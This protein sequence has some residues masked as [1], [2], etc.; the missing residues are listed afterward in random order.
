MHDQLRTPEANPLEFSLDAA[1]EGMAAWRV[2]PIRAWLEQQLTPAHPD[3]VRDL[4]VLEATAWWNA[5][6]SDGVTETTSRLVEAARACPGTLAPFLLFVRFASMLAW[7]QEWEVLGIREVVGMLVAEVRPQER[8]DP[9]VDAALRL[10]TFLLA[11]FAV[12]AA[13]LGG[14]LS[15]WAEQAEAAAQ[16]GARLVDVVGGQGDGPVLAYVADQAA[17]E[18]AYYRA[19]SRAAGAAAGLPTDRGAALP[20]AIEELRRVEQ[21]ED[22]IDR[23]ELRAHRLSLQALQT[24]LDRPWLEIHSGRVVALF[25]F[26]AWSRGSGPA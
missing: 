2:G 26:A 17:G 22:P 1:I 21:D 7:E 19:V 9:E 25:P 11:E 23:S 18:V 4:A 13:S 6:G 16:D 5:Q 8:R 24:A 10:L 3:C 20:G 15:D 14:Q 12:E